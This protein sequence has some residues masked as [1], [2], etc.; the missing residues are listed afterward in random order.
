MNA[1]HGAVGAAICSSG[2]LN[3]SDSFIHDN[4]ASDQGGGIYNGGT[5]TLNGCRLVNNQAST[6]GAIYT[7][8][9]LT[10]DHYKLPAA[11][12][13][14]TAAE[15]ISTLIR[16]CRRPNQ[17]LHFNNNSASGYGGAIWYQGPGT[18]DDSASP[19]YS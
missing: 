16:Q 18:G 9:T 12:R 19:D 15:F 17:E 8:G 10:M 13:S 2:P 3:V 6:G 11:F 7:A 5:L 1:H 14:T 4:I